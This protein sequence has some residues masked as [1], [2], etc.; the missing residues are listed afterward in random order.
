MGQPAPCAPALYSADP[1]RDFTPF[2]RPQCPRADVPSRPPSEISKA[3]VGVGVGAALVACGAHA[4]RM[5]PVRPLSVWHGP[6][7]PLPPSQSKG[8]GQCNEKYGTECIDP[9]LVGMRLC[10]LHNDWCS[11]A[12]LV[13]HSVLQLTLS[14]HRSLNTIP[15]RGYA[16]RPSILERFSVRSICALMCGLCAGL[17]GLQSEWCPGV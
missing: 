3:L 8:C 10:M 15:G 12:Y 9:P 6:V 5:E 4:L 1:Y 7:P 17:L 13:G 14:H 16:A 2:D 11:Y